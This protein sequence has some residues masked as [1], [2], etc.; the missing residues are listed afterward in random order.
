M[1]LFNAFQSVSF[2]AAVPFGLSWLADQS[3]RGAG[4]GFWVGCVIYLVAFCWNVAAVRY[5]IDEIDW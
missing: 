2:F 3:F 1:K 5:S 4:I